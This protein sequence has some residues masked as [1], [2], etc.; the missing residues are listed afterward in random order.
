MRLPYASEL[1]YRYSEKYSTASVR[2]WSA[3]DEVLIS[4][5]PN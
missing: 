3:V 2:A 5:P 4:S 1:A